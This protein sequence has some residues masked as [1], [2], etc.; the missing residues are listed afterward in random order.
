MAASGTAV[1]ILNLLVFGLNYLS[2]RDFDAT[3]PY[4]LPTEPQVVALEGL[5]GCVDGFLLHVGPA[6]EEARGEWDPLR[7]VTGIVPGWDS[8]GRDDGTTCYGAEGLQSPR[9][10]QMKPR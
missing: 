9:V 2:A 3:N 5:A 10:F 4:L 8:E 1:I 6:A 7:E